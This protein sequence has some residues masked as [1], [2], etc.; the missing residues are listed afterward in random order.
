MAAPGQRGSQA[1]LALGTGYVAPDP[2]PAHA[3]HFPRAALICQRFLRGACQHRDCKFLHPAEHPPTPP[4]SPPRS[5]SRPPRSQQPS[6]SRRTPRMHPPRKGLA[7]PPSREESSSSQ[8][9]R[10]ATQTPAAKSGPMRGKGPRRPSLGRRRP[11]DSSCPTKPLPPISS[12]TASKPKQRQARSPLLVGRSPRGP[13]AQTPREQAPCSRGRTRREAAPSNRS[14]PVPHHR[15]CR[16]H[17]DGV[18]QHP[19]PCPRTRRRS[20]DPSRPSLPST[21][22]RRRGSRRTTRFEL[23]RS[24]PPA[25]QSARTRYVSTPPA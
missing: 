3:A 23:P 25:T 5:R 21:H 11:W 20:P 16:H 8:R 13:T 19:F 2:P 24:A 7:P 1:T 22:L 17:P 15:R 9:P 14:I 12:G 4:P 10:S 6:P 18:S